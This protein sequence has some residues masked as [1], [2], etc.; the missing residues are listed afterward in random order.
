MVAAGGT[1]PSWCRGWQPWGG[2]GLQAS[3]GEPSQPVPEVPVA[4][5]ALPS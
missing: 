4:A 1:S 2:H 5:T 3:Q